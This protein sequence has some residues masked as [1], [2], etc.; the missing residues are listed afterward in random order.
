MADCSEMQGSC[1]MLPQLSFVF[2]FYIS[3]LRREEIFQMH[4]SHH[5]W[6]CSLSPLKSEETGVTESGTVRVRQNTR[7]TPQLTSHCATRRGLSCIETKAQSR[8][9]LPQIYATTP[10]MK[11]CST[12]PLYSSTTMRECEH[13]SSIQDESLSP[14]Y[15]PASQ[16]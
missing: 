9:E 15:F 3:S 14:E 10:A 4:V 2:Y 13:H 5:G 8:C 6:C 7:E 12:V 1:V 11:C 16:Q